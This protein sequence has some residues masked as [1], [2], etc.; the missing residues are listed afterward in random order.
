MNCG[1]AVSSRA[2]MSVRRRPKNPRAAVRICRPARC[3]RGTSPRARRRRESKRYHQLR[4]RRSLSMRNWTVESCSSYIVT[5]L[6][7]L[8]GVFVGWL[9]CQKLC[10][11]KLELLDL[12]A[13]CGA[14][15]DDVEIEPARRVGRRT[16]NLRFLIGAAA[17]V[18]P[19]SPC[20][21]ASFTANPKN[22]KIKIQMALSC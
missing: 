3:P 5:Y 11:F 7:L 16:S 14:P 19:L 15:R 8:R 1:S 21:F 4:A 17:N 9:H 20:A 18:R 22:H 12:A 2:A 13:A 6:V 10:C